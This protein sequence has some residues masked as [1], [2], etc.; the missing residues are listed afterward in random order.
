MNTS[1]LATTVILFLNS[2]TAPSPGTKLHIV[3]KGSRRNHER[4]FRR[5]TRYII[6]HT[7]EGAEGGALEKL[8]REGEAHY[9]VGRDGT[10][11]RIVNRQKVAA[12]TGLAMWEGRINLDNHALGI[13]VAGYHDDNPTPA[14][15]SAL[16]RLLHE[17]QNIYNIPDIRVLT[18]SMVAY[19]TPNRWH[20]H[21]HRGRKRC[22]MRLAAPDIRAKL[23]LDARPKVDPD[24]SSGRLVVADKKLH[25]TLY[26]RQDS[27][28]ATGMSRTSDATNS[29]TSSIRQAFVSA[30]ILPST[31]RDPLEDF[32]STREVRHKTSRR[33]QL[34]DYPPSA[35]QSLNDVNHVDAHGI[36]HTSSQKH[37]NPHIIE[38]TSK[39]AAKE[40]LGNSYDARTTIYLFPDGLVR[41]GAELA[42]HKRLSVLLR[43]TPRGT[44]V[45]QDY[46]Y[47]GYLSFNRSPQ[48]I[49]GHL[50][51]KPQTLYRFPDGILRTG[52]KLQSNSFPPN[53]MIFFPAR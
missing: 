48:S 13:E 17:L 22:A 5:H 52:D 31:P 4:P 25:T 42:K 36:Q 38:F 41:T 32:Y 1:A 46:F 44:R 30:G 43:K 9:M 26:P 27:H 45:L 21:P 18:H 6:L 37:N 35:V 12:H 19:G 29:L 34:S 2:L 16:K 15:L 8:S 51:N 39:G 7:T 40:V 28:K 53:T 3:Q 14:Q 23:G 47:G 10:V 33:N 11:Y 24:V 20:R 50:W 49:C